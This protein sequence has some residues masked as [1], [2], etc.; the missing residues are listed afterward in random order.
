MREEV[1]Q[2]A[3][4]CAAESE[5]DDTSQNRAH[6][7]GGDDGSPESIWVAGTHL[8]NDQVGHFVEERNHLNHF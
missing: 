2:R 6:G 4:L 7:V 3:K 8:T 1:D 5:E